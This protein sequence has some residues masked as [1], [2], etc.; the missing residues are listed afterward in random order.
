MALNECN[1]VRVENL[2]DRELKSMRTL[3]SDVSHLIAK[4]ADLAGKEPL[5]KEILDDLETVV[6]E[7]ATEP[8]EHNAAAQLQDIRDGL[9]D[10]LQRA[11]AKSELGIWIF[12]KTRSD[13][14]KGVWLMTAKTAPAALVAANL[15]RRGFVFAAL[16]SIFGGARLADASIDDP[17]ELNWTDLRPLKS[18]GYASDPQALS[19]STLPSRVFSDP[20]AYAVVPEYKGKRVKL[21]GY[22][23]PLDLGRAGA[24]EFLLVPFV[25]AC[26]HVPPP[27]P[28]QIVYAQ[29]K[30]PFMPKG[31]F[32]PVY[33]IGVLDTVLAQ[34][35]FASASYTLTVEE[36]ETVE[37]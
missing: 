29:I 9:L 14:T 22:L 30:E 2:D 34:T 21:P 13:K 20:R 36:F 7:M 25:G 8:L 37:F 11:L 24:T 17:L 35:D 1:A 23:I 31:M 26:I 3:K 10:E 15:N 6:K 4:A 33:A 19:H 5:L 28:N 12:V 27:P 32:H 16:A 18:R